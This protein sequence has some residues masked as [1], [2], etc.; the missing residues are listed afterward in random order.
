M[1]WYHLI[2]LFMYKSNQYTQLGLIIQYLSTNLQ[3]REGI[4]TSIVNLSKNW[5]VGLHDHGNRFPLLIVSC[6]YCFLLSNFKSL[7]LCKFSLW[8]CNLSRPILNQCPISL[9]CVNVSNIVDDKLVAWT[10]I[11]GTVTNNRTLEY[12]HMR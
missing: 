10:W 9:L 12:T 3:A 11:I 2:K 7:S 6:S 1:I 5:I 8:R 4:Y